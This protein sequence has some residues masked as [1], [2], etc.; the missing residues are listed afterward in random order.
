MALIDIAIST[1]REHVLYGTPESY[2]AVCL[3]LPY[4]NAV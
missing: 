4:K 1:V 2:A 3:R